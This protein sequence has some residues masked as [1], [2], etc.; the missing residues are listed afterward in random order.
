[1]SLTPSGA[2]LGTS[3]YMAPEQAGRSASGG[4]AT[5]GPASDVYSLGAILYHMLTGRPPFQAATPVETILLALE[6]DPISPRALNPRVSPDLEMIA[7][8]CLQKSPAL[9]YPSAAA[10]AEDLEAFLRGD[11]VWARATSLRALATRLLGE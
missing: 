10:L 1:P 2:L 5:V 11:P 4:R 6:H 8:K 3:S 9:R 7:L